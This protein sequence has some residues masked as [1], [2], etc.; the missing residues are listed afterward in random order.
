[1][2]GTTR[3]L[4]LAAITTSALVIFPIAAGC[5]TS[6][7]KTAHGPAFNGTIQT[8]DVASHLLTV[9]PLKPDS[10]PIVFQWDNRSRFW[11]NGGLPIEPTLLEPRDNV[12]IHYHADSKP[13]TI[14]HLY[15]ETHRTIH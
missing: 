8:V 7:W 11:A 13:W 3:I 1:V 15:L 2:I 4:L 5:S 14:Q 12:R 9:A 10:T 6:S